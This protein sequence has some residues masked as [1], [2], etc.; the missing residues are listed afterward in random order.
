MRITL[1][2]LVLLLAGIAATYARYESLSP[3][4]WM[5][6]DL[7][8]KSGLPEIVVKARIQAA[9]LLEGIT[10]PDALQCLTEWWQLR[11]E[12]LPEEP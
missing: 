5:E 11:S 6:R 4:I 9:F 12:G 1:V 10:E 7:A 3:C 2:L 8:A